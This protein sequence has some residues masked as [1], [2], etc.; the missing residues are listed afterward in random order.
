MSRLIIFLYYSITMLNRLS[1]VNLHVK[2]PHKGDGSFVER[3]SQ[4]WKFE[5]YPVETEPWN[6]TL[7]QSSQQSSVAYGHPSD[8]MQERFKVTSFC[9]LVAVLFW[10]DQG[11]LNLMERLKKWKQF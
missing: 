3:S 7:S 9:K 4:P 2:W 8:L 5:N 11:S 10:Y 6:F 1:L